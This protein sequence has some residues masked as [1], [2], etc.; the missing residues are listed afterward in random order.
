MDIE[1]IIDKV[2]TETV[3]K[4]KKSNLLKDDRKSAFTKTETILKNYNKYL[5]AI[6]FDSE[7]TIKTQKLITIID[8]ALKTIEDDPYCDVITM[9][10]FEDKTREEIAEFYDVDVK[11]IS[12]HKKKLVNELKIIIFSDKSIEEIFL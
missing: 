9:Y 6:K 5:N 1:K 2:T 4:L 12:R 7:E 10:Y 11:T 3:V 8:N